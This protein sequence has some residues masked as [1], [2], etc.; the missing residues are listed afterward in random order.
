MRRPILT[1]P[2][3]A[4]IGALSVVALFAFATP[5]RT[6]VKQSNGIRVIF[7]GSLTPRSLPRRGLGP[8]RVAVG[9]TIVPTPG[10]T[11]PALR[12]ISIEINRHGH[13]DTSAL[14]LCRYDAIQ[15]STTR[16]ALLNCGASLVGKGHFSSTVLQPE[17]APFPS[18]GQLYA[19]N[20]TYKGK[21]AIL[22]H[23]YG[24]EP[25]PV[26]YTIPFVLSSAKGTYGTTM[27]AP[28]PDVGNE[29]GFITGLSLNLGRTFHSRGERH[30][31]VSAG[32]PVPHGFK[33]ASFPLARAGFSF[34][35]GS[36]LRSVLNRSCRALG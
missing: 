9:A 3:A 32:C 27:T 33:V 18:D 6:E 5:G 4:L 8:V 23:I 1:R 7:T 10:T 25:I 20:G 26:S 13:F 24:I 34:A 16:N 14:P 12:K 31:Y 22:A 29:W 15:P 21:P 36:T 19:F 2:R 11:P 17:A 35:D 30:G 28:M